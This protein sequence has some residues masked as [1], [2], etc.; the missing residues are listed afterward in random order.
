MALSVKNMLGGGGSIGSVENLLVPTLGTETRNGITCT[1]N[2]DGTFTL[3]GTSTANALFLVGYV[4]VASGQS[5]KLSG[6]PKGGNIDNGYFMYIG[7]ENGV[8]EGNGQIYNV[9][10]PKKFPVQ[11]GVRANNTLNNLIFKP[12]LTTN[13]K[14]TYK[15]FV[16]RVGGFTNAL[17]QTFTTVTNAGVTATPNGDGTIT[18]SGTSTA[19]SEIRL[20]SASMSY[21]G[22]YKLTGTPVGLLGTNVYLQMYSSSTGTMLRERDK[23]GAI[24]TLNASDFDLRIKFPN[25]Y[26]FNNVIFKPMLTESLLPEYFDFVKGVAEGITPQMFGCTKMAVDSFTLASDTVMPTSTSSPKYFS[27]SLGVKPVFMAI[28]ADM[29]INTTTTRYIYSLVSYRARD[30]DNGSISAMATA[31]G[32]MG[33]ENG[34]WVANLTSATQIALA[35]SGSSRYLKGGVTYKVITM[36]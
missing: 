2:G 1:S 6:C 11:I 5:Y 31:N 34:T 23:I 13:L 7:G 10:S 24:G 17:A 35:L 29:P 14:A 20:L 21:N 22:T 19:D 8:D 36:A 26:T 3:S 12:M 15:E 30:V 27:H 32:A 33:S 16:K 18:L 4:D 28:I 9:T 25:N